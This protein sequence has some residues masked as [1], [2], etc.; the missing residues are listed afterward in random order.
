MVGSVHHDG[1]RHS[2]SRDD[3]VVA[4]LLEYHHGSHGTVVAALLEYHRGSHGTV[5]ARLWQ[6]HY[7]RSQ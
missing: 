6:Y 2:S 4:A 1:P 7:G 5:V 3:T